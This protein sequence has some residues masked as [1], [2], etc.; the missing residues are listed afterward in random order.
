MDALL[1]EVIAW[2][3]KPSHQQVSPLPPKLVQLLAWDLYQ[4][5]RN[6][7]IGALGAIGLTL[8]VILCAFFNQELTHNEFLAVPAIFFAIA[9]I[10]AIPSLV[11]L[12][13]ISCQE[14]WCIKN[15][16]NIYLAAWRK[17]S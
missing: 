5:V 9:S 4:S 1:K 3:D 17:N 2:N 14:V 10:L 16:P 15:T 11:Y 6:M 12:W 8:L 13:Y 7:W